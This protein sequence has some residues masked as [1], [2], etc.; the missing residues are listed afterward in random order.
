MYQRFGRLDIFEETDKFRF[1]F[2]VSGGYIE[3][4]VTKI[5]I[6]PMNFS[7]DSNIKCNRNVFSIFGLSVEK[8]LPALCAACEDS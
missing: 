4:I 7:V 2:R 8:A 1:E 5:K 6:S 3:R